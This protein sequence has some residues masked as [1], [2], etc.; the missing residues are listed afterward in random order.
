M[1]GAQRVDI[2]PLSI[3]GPLLY[4]RSSQHDDADSLLRI[5]S[6][7]RIGSIVS[8]VKKGSWSGTQLHFTKYNRIHAYANRTL[9]MHDKIYFPIQIPTHEKRHVEMHGHGAGADI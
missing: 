1:T 4:F 5:T 8:L 3:S 2:P 9:S 6:I 7:M